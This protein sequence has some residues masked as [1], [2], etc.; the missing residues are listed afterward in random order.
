MQGAQGASLLSGSPASEAGFT[1][2]GPDFLRLRRLDVLFRRLLFEPMSG[3]PK[4]AARTRAA[5]K[6][7]AAYGP[8]MSLSAFWKV[9]AR[10]NLVAGLRMSATWPLM[11][12]SPAATSAGVSPRSSGDEE[13]DLP[14]EDPPPCAPSPLPAWPAAA[15]EPEPAPPPAAAPPPVRA[16][17]VVTGFK[18]PPACPMIWGSPGRGVWPSTYGF[19]QLAAVGGAG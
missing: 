10:G 9:S 7:K 4:I 15:P 12:R 2:L 1:T 17:A 8:P 19:W 18:P 14:P 13:P 16:A 6:R 3:G 5:Q 11:I